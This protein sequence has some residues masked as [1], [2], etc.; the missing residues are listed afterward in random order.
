MTVTVIGPQGT[1]PGA[2][3]IDLAGQCAWLLP[4]KAL[5][6][7]AYQALLAADVHLGKAVSYRRLG[8]PVPE[9]TTDETLDRLTRALALTGARRL[10]F[11]GDLLHSA[12]AHAAATL[13]LVQRWR[14]DHAA[15]EML[16]VRG[17]H[18]LHAGD[19]PPALDIPAVDAP[20]LLGPFALVHAPDDAA[21]QPYYRLAG[22]VHPA[23]SLGGRAHVH[24]R[25][26]CFHLGPATG[27]LPA[28]GAFTGMH[29]LRRCSADRVYAIVE[30]AV[31]AV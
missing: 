15:I 28:F 12:H 16:L 29:T 14:D 2:L 4:H 17:N 19:P 6:L 8:V 18:D 20:V 22:H 11:L 31:I 27:V 21:P 9:A 3:S 5:Y 23:V 13:A 24:L 30:Q 25:L 10:L 7:P 26:P 1:I